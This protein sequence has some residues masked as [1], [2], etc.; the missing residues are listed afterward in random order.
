MV[1]GNHYLAIEARNIMMSR[2]KEAQDFRKLM[3]EKMFNFGLK[4]KLE[5]DP[6]KKEFVS[7]EKEFQEHWR[8]IFKQ[9]VLNRYLSLLEEKKSLEKEKIKNSKDKDGKKLSENK[10][11][12]LKI[13]EKI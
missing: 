8:K 7:T 11:A 1:N 4:E 13:D 10:K 6:D 12:Q 5:L 3:F 9:S 2:I